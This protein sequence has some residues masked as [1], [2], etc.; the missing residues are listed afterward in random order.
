MIPTL[1]A[2]QNQR[3]V[4]EEIKLPEGYKW[5]SFAKYGGKITEG[6]KY[7][8]YFDGWKDF[9][10]AWSNYM[11]VVCVPKKYGKISEISVLKKELKEL[12]KKINDAKIALG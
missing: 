5:A 4:N 12:K 3:I 2:Y 10:D 8:T 7:F 11:A 9:S 1:T 6:Q